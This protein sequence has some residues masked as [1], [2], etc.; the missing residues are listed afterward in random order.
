M[1][2]PRTGLIV[3]LIMLLAVSSQAVTMVQNEALFKGDDPRLEKKIS[4]DAEGKRLIEVFSDL[5]KSTEVELN[6]GEDKNDWLVY[7]RKVII[8]VKDMALRDLMQE[9]AAVLRFHWSRGGEDGKWNYRM[10]QD[11]QQREEEE[12]L[13]KSSEDQKAQQ[14]REKRE[15]ALSDIA[16]LGSLSSTDA[17]SLKADSPWRYVLATQPLGKD[18]AAFFDSFAE[19]RNAFIQGHESTF[20]V[21]QLPQNVQAMVRRIAESY[22]SLE[23]SIGATEDH[24]DLLSRFDKLQV[25]INRRSLSGNDDA[26][27]RSLLGRISIG[28][29]SES[30]EIPLFDPASP[31]AKALGSAIVALQGGASKDAVGKQLRTDMETVVS[32]GEQATK[33]ARDTSSDPALRQ[34]VKLFDVDNNAPLPMTLKA[35]AEK[36]KTNVVSDYFPGVI[37]TISG[38]EKTLGDQLEAI[39]AAYGI[40][41]TK[42]SGI[43]QF[44]DKEWYKKRSWDVPEE[45][46]NYWSARGKKNDGL[47]FIDLVQI[48]C[49]RDDQIDHTIMTNPSLV[50]YGAGE[51]ARNR[52]ILRFYGSLSP[53]QQNLMSAQNQKL[54]VSA[55]SAEQWQIL[56]DALA[57][58]G[59]AYAAATQTSQFLQMTRS[60]GEGN[61]NDIIYYPND[62]DPAVHFKMETGTLYG[63]GE[64]ISVPPKDNVAPIDKR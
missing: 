30:F 22:D 61:E 6:A 14:F 53:D 31:M 63:V 9:I 34:S 10:W 5:S 54:M 43:I 50:T 37:A 40:N 47:Q 60:G 62:K 12:S 27:S 51:A 45:W 21:S 39:S 35:L 1:S 17:A 41:W 23:G 13:L 44:R 4:F 38:G 59:V 42:D 64:E 2:Y 7:D 52:Q 55:L 16:N 49:L 26:L 56:Q 20:A 3:L 58:K 25:T 18:V 24:A 28:S 46:I 29:G 48:G 32:L 19:A 36:A 15:N 57:K 11:K 33:T 8:H